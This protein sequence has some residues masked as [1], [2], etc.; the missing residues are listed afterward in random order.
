MKYIIFDLEFNQDY[1]ILKG[2]KINST[3]KCPFEILQLGALK[4]D[5]KFQRV[6]TLNRLV[7]PDI[8]KSLNPFIKKMTGIREVQLINAKPFKEVYQEFIEFIKDD[9][10]VLCVWGITD[11][12]ELFR[13][14][15]YHGIST[16]SL[17]KKYI[18]IQSYASK[19]LSCKKN[20]SIGLCNA[21]E[22]L[23]ISRS[24]PFHDAFND[25]F[26]TA[27]ILKRIYNE[28][29]LPQLYIAK[30]LD[31]ISVAKTKKITLDNINLL[32]QFE[33]MFQ[34]KMTCEEKT[35]IKL[36]YIM[37]KTNQFKI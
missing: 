23:N 34:R 37:G 30:K 28:Q 14:M 1:P 25:A 26:Y 16:S 33:K 36:A 8:Y 21:V 2:S 13:N 35:I 32:K 27:E 15:E 12:K 31:L 5:E 4:L 17:P 7:K 9:S 19:Y 24:M 22:L 29:M 10:S 3:N 20:V 18:N 11:I 6:S